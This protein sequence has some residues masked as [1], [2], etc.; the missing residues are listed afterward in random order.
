MRSIDAAQGTSSR[1]QMAVS[2]SGT[3]GSAVSRLCGI[4]TDKNVMRAAG[5]DGIR[6]L[7]QPGRVR[8]VPGKAPG[9]RGYGR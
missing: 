8:M 9:A 7:H 4:G 6:G 1:N 5:G 2:G 3:T